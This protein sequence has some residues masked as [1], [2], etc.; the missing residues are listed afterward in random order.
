MKKFFLRH[1][2]L[3]IWLLAVLGLLAAFWLLRASRGAMTAMAG[4]AS[5]VR[6]AL[7]RAC[8]LVP[9]SV[10]ELL[11]VA[12]AVS[13]AAYLVWSAAAIVRAGSRGRRAYSALLGAVCA[14]LTIYT[15]FC[16]LW[17]VH[18]YTDTFQDRSGIYA[19][20]VAAQDLEAVTRYFADRLRETADQ[21]HR[22]GDGL[23]AES[24]AEILAQSPHVY[25]ALER[26]YPFLAFDD[27]GVKPVYFSR[28]MSALNFTGIYCPFTGEPNV[29]M[30]SPACLLPST[31]AHEM[32]HQRSVALEQEC[33]FLA[34]LAC[35][36]CGSDVYAYS[37]WLL[38]YIHLGNALYRV[39]PDAWRELRS[40]LPEAV[41]ADLADNNA[42]WDQFEGGVAQK[43][44]NQVY[45]GFLKSYGEEDGLAS[46][47]TVVDLLV[48]YYRDDASTAAA[49]TSPGTAVIRA[50]LPPCTSTTSIWRSSGKSSKRR[51][52]I[53]LKARENGKEGCVRETREGCP[54][55]L[56]S[57]VFQNFSKF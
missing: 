56:K 42:Y 27:T 41:Q 20:P 25:D 3:H 49:G 47:G 21:V 7:G 48:V 33:N 53:N 55:P 50:G 8:A 6:A 16:Y 1:R 22:D 5:A 15:G 4:A 38:G 40:S 37:G 52:S 26:Q 10:A 14:G 24:R 18:Y 43:V 28:V 57:T 31:V 54:A 35:T 23:F 34:I 13:I 51:L 11:C 29:N 17:G 30:D 12:L 19:Q 39:N 32:A 9:F 45:E 44:S 46:Y 2:K 36:T